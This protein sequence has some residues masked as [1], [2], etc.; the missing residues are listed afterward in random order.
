MWCEH[1]KAHLGA[2]MRLV[3]LVSLLWALDGLKKD[4][5]D[6]VHWRKHLFKVSGFLFSLR[7]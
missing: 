6:S 5:L 1:D 2:N 4:S 3:S 7:I